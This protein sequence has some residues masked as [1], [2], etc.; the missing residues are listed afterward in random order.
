M[1]KLSVHSAT[2]Q[3]THVTFFNDNWD[4]C[5]KSVHLNMLYLFL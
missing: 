1:Y 4:F 2:I 5:V 3:C